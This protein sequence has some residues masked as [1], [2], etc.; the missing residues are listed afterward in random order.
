MSKNENVPELTNG[1]FKE[2]I[3]KGVSF[4]DFYADW[5][6]PCMMMSPIIEE[7]A[8]TFKGRIKF[9]KV[10]VSENE[11]L[12]ESFN[13]SS[14]PNMKIFKNGEIAAEMVGAVSAEELENRLKSYLK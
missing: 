11:E 14:I 5:C 4:V 3:K 1:E 10:N 12:A 8:E 9:G 6:M 7:L 13:V 2:F